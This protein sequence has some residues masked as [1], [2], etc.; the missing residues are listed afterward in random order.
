VDQAHRVGDHR[1][2]AG[3][4]VAQVGIGDVVGRQREPV[5]DLGQDQVLLFE[6]DLELLPEDLGVEQVLDPQADAGRL[7]GVG[8]ADTPLGGA[9]AVLAQLALGEAVEL[10]VVRHD[11]VGVAADLEPGAVDAAG[12][13]PVDLGHQ[14]GGVDHHPVADH[15]SDPRVKNAAGHELQGEGFLADDDGVAGVVAAL[16]ADHDLHLLGE[17]IGQLALALV[18]PLGADDH[19]TGHARLLRNVLRRSDQCTAPVH[20]LHSV[21]RLKLFEVPPIHGLRHPAKPHQGDGEADNNWAPP[22]QGAQSASPSPTFGGVPAPPR[23]LLLLRHGQSVWNADGRWQ[24]QADPPLSPLGEAQARDGAPRL[25]ALG[26]ARLVASDLQRALRTAE[27]VAGPL[28]LAVEVDRDLREID[29]G[30]WT[31]MT[32]AEIEAEWPGELADWSEGRSESTIGGEPRAQ[33]TARARAALLRAAAEVGPGDR[34]LLVSHG[35]L[36]RNLDRLLG[37]QPQGVPNLGGRWYESDGNGSLT[38]A[39]LVSLADPE[40]R[41]L[42]SSP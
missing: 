11:Q 28:G 17:Q 18:A 21:F 15:R 30:D 42:S 38:P 35:A 33:L 26:F 22:R 41:T 10:G 34:V 8:R 4:Q 1:L 32:R 14:H 37:L 24:G 40:D 39:E 7:V 3:P 23:R 36:I 20:G 5:V 27:I 19:G 2:D 25:A 13:E 16:V 6:D 9:Q 12:L 29:V 31:G